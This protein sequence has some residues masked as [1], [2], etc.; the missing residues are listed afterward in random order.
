MRALDLYPN[1]Y[2]RVA[3]LPLLSGAHPV[4]SPTVGWLDDCLGRLDIC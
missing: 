2:R 3:W 1:L 4:Q